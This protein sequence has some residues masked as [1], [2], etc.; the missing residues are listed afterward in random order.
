[1]PSLGAFV[2]VD[3]LDSS[4][5]PRNGTW[6]EVQVER[7][8]VDARSWTIILDGRRFQRLADRH[9]LGLFSLATFQT[10]E[11]GVDLPE[12]LQFSLGG[13]NT[14]RGWRVGS[15]TGRNQFIGTGEYTYVAWKVTPFSVFGVNAYAGIQIA[16]FADLGL[17]SNDSADGQSTAAWGEP[18]RGATTYFGIS[19]KAARQRQR[20]R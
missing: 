1:M 11:V 8:A 6:A 9:G 18:G 10:G 12:Y 19:L 14:V 15:R 2:S 20:V 16:A 7:L 4:T 3:T 5:D 13:A 17:T